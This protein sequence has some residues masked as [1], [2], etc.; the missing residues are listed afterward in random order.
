MLSFFRN[1]LLAMFAVG[2]GLAGLT[3]IFAIKKLKSLG[4]CGKSGVYVVTPQQT[5]PMPVGSPHSSPSFSHRSVTAPSSTNYATLS[6][7]SQR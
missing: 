2:A 4:V 5:P 7:T 6:L 3:A 1:V